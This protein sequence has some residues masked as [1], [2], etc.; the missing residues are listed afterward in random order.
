MIVPFGFNLLLELTYLFIVQCKSV[1][2]PKK[3]KYIILEEFKLILESLV[4]AKRLYHDKVK[5][6][7]QGNFLAISD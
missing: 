7:E 1:V 3:L 4:E 6:N 2:V 5:V